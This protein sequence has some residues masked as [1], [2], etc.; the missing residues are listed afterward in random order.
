M[1]YVKSKIKNEGFYYTFIHYSRFEKIDDEK[2]HELRRN[3]K[4][5]VDAMNDYLESEIKRLTENE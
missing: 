2:F 5:S 3:F 1:E 4:E